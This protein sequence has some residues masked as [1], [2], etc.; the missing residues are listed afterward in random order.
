MKAARAGAGCRPVC[1]MSSRQTHRPEGWTDGE[2]TAGAVFVVVLVVAAALTAGLSLYS[3]GSAGAG[4]LPSGPRT[5]TSPHGQPS[6][7][8]TGSAT[9]NTTSPVTA[10]PS[11]SPP[12]APAPTGDHGKAVPP[13]V[14]AALSGP[15]GTP[16]RLDDGRIGV[17]VRADVPLTSADAAAVNATGALFIRWPGGGLGDRFDPIADDGAGVVYA[18]NGSDSAPPATTFAQFATWCGWVHCQSVVTLPAEIDNA[19]L[20]AQIVSYSL[21]TLDFSPTYWEIGNEPAG[22]THFD[23]PW[24]EWTATQNVSVTPAEFALVVQSYTAAILAVD[25]TAQIIGLGGIGTGQ[26]PGWVQSDVAVNGPNLSGVAI[27]IYPMGGV[28]ASLPLSSWYDSLD[29]GSVVPNHVNQTIQEINE[30]CPTCNL[31]VLIDELGSGTQVPAA[32]GLSGGALGAYIGTEMISSLPLN[33][34]SMDY[35]NLQ[36]GTQGAWFAMNGTPSAAYTFFLDWAQ[37]VGHYAGELRVAATTPG[38]LAAVGGSGPHLMKNLIL[39]NISPTAEFTVNLSS[40][41]PDAGNGSLVVWPSGSAA[42]Y[43]AQWG[44]WGPTRLS[45]LPDS[46]VILTDVGAPIRDVSHSPSSPTGAPPQPPGGA[47]PAAA[48]SVMRT[49]E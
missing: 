33:I 31:S 36:S 13:S 37:L 17:D 18:L 41:F 11:P 26:T 22:W 48:P 1:S 29:N 4:G 27:H 21:H 38:L 14:N 20:A 9:S 23:I 15:I 32:D 6:G 42:P 47:T 8:G 7:G 40:T 49:Q 44:I 2:V 45:V 39:V 5:G 35:Y 19:S 3:A 16:V 30:T 28:N 34:R 10:P 24:S 12:P 43:P 46:L 25:P